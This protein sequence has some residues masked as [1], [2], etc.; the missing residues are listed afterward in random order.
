MKNIFK[1]IVSI[2][3][4]STV[5]NTQSVKAQDVIYG[6]FKLAPTYLIPTKKI[7]PLKFSSKIGYSIGY[8]EVL[9]LSNKINLQAELNYSSYSYKL[10]TEGS[11]TE[12]EQELKGIELPLMIKYRANNNFAI[13]AGYQFGLGAQKLSGMLFD[14][15]VKSNK[16]IFGLRA[17]FLNEDESA[18]M[19]G[20]QSA[21]PIA[22]SLY[23]GF[24]I[25]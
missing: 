8:Y 3:F 5:F 17:L 22:T 15:N 24:S 11:T 14:M 1:L 7:D 2:F 4:L 19:F 18:V 21:K 23:L 12:T 13:G 10:K 9:E 20:E 25:F 6:G 16:T